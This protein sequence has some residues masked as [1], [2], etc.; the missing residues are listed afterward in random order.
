[1]TDALHGPVAVLGMACLLP[2]ARDLDEYWALL[3]EGR[4]ATGEYPEG[5]LNRALY[6][7]PRR[8]QLGK[9]YSTTGGLVDSA[10][11]E[12]GGDEFDVCHRTFARVVDQALNQA[13]LASQ[14]LSCRRV[15]IYV[16]H[17]GG[18]PELGDLV[19]A[20]MAEN[21]AQVL[22]QTSAFRRLGEQQQQALLARFVERLREGK[23]R[24]QPGGGPCWEARW[25][26]EL[27]A[28][29]HGLSGPNLVVD[30]ACAS[31]LVALALAALAL[32]RGEID[33]A[34]V[35]G[36]SI[37]KT[38]SLLLFSQAQSCSSKRSRPF[39]DLA[40]GLIGSEG[41]VAMVL[42]RAQQDWTGPAL[43]LISGIGLSSDGRGRHLWAPLREG[44]LS[45]LKRAYAGHQPATVQYIEAHATSTQVG[46]ATE[47]ESLREFFA[48]HLG[49]QKIPI[50]SVKSNIGHT[51]ETAGLASLLKVILSMRQAEIPPT[52]NLETPNR[53]IDWDSLPFEVVRQPRAWPKPEA[54][55]RRAGVSAFGIGGLNVH[56]VV[57]EPDDSASFNSS[58]LQAEPVAIIGRGLVAAGA[59]NLKQFR[60]RLETGISALGEAPGS[61]W[62]DQIGLSAT[63]EDWTTPTKRGGYVVEHRYDYLKHRVPP[64]QLERANPLQFMLLD[65]ADQAFQEAGLTSR[66]HTAAVVGTVFGGEFS[67]RLLLGLR[68][69]EVQA[70]LKG[71]LE[72]EQG[73]LLT[74]F[75]KAYFERF[76]ALL[77]ETGGFTS[78]TLASRL[79]KAFDLEGGALALEAGSCS[80][81]L[82]LRV[83]TALLQGG[84]CS[85]VLCAAGQTSLDLVGFEHLAR[86]GCFAD[87]EFFPGE[88]ASVVLLKRLADARRD[89][90]PIF[91]VLLGDGCAYG[92]RSVEQASRL[93]R[94]QAGL[95]EA[96]SS[97][98]DL[99]PLL[100][101]LGAAAGL[102]RVIAATLQPSD[103]PVE[104]QSAGRSGLA[105]SLLLGPPASSRAEP[106]LLRWSATT[107][108]ELGRGPAQDRF[109][110]DHPYRLA[111][112]ACTTFEQSQL[113]QLALDQMGQPSA[114]ALLEDKG[115]FWGEVGRR[116]PRL[117]YVF[118]GQGSQ[119]PGMM[120]DLTACSKS[121]RAVLE[122]AEAVLAGMGLPGFTQFA[123]GDGE[124]LNQDPVITQLAILIAD[125]MMFAALTEYGLEP[126]VVCGHSFG[127][128]AAL[129][130]AR[131]LTLEQAL[132]LTRVRAQ[133]LLQASP[134]G[135]LLSVQASP[136]K[137]LPLLNG[138]Q[139]YLTHRNAPQQCVIG[140]GNAELDQLAGLLHSQGLASLRLKVP[141]A[142][143]TP[144][145]APAQ[146][147]LRQQLEAIQLLP[148]SRLFYSGVN[149]A[150]VVDPVLIRR[151]LV[152]QLVQPVDHPAL[153][154]RLLADGVGALIEVG[155]G[156]VLTRLHRQ[157]VDPA[158]VLCLACDH[159]KR[160]PEEQRLRLRAALESRGLLAPLATPEKPAGLIQ[161][162]SLIEFDATAARRGRNR[163]QSEQSSA[164]AP[165][166]ASPA[167]DRLAEILLDFVVDLTGYPREAISLDWDLEAD[168]G[169]DSIKRTQ[170]IG[171][172]GEALGLSPP[173]GISLDRVT[174]LRELLQ[175][176]RAA[177]KGE[178]PE[179]ETRAAS[180][181]PTAYQE[182]RARGLRE[183]EDIRRKLRDLALQP[184]SEWPLAA[185]LPQSF[186]SGQL[187]ELQGVAD[188]A[189]VHLGALLAMT[190]PSLR[191]PSSQLCLRYR[192]GMVPLAVGPC[193]EPDWKGG[194]LILGHD[195]QALV[196]E[197]ELKQRGLP[198]QRL[199]PR[200]P[201]E[202]LLAQLEPHP[203]L[204][205]CASGP[206]Q[207]QSCLI[208]PY[209]VCQRWL[210]RL[211]Q[212]E[213]ME[214]ASLVALTRLGGDFG[215]TG[216]SQD[217][218][219]AP[220][221][222]LCKAI[223]VESWVAGYRWL[224]VKVIDS[225]LELDA[226]HCV[227]A[228]LLE[229]A[230]PGYDCEIGL[231]GGQR[232]VLRCF[233]QAAPAPA[234]DPAWQPTGNWI[235]SGGARGITAFVG[236][237]LA[238]RYGL[239][240]HLLGR[241]PRREFP[242]HWRQL[243]AEGSR[244][245]KLEVL[246]QARLGGEPN[247]AGV[248]ERTNKQL[249]IE[250][251]L[252]HF[253]SQG[254]EVHYYSC[255]LGQREQLR[256][257]L[258]KIREFGPIRGILH[259][260]GA[261]RDAKFEHKE[262]GRVEQCFAAK[263][264]GTFNL[265]ELTEQ[266]PLTHVLAFGSISGRF[267]ANGHTDY[268][269]AN[270]AMAKI[271]DRYRCSRPEVASTTIHWHAWGDVG[272]AVKAEAQYGLELVDI[273]FMP[274]AEGLQHLLA[275][276]LAGA[277]EPEVLITTRDYCARFSLA[278]SGPTEGRPL[279]GQEGCDELWLDPEKEV[280]LKEHRLDGQPMLPLVIGLE[281]LCESALP[282]RPGPFRVRQVEALNGL[283]FASSQPLKVCLQAGADGLMRLFG[284]MR[285]RDGTLLDPARPILQ[286]QIS[287]DTRSWPCQPG[288]AA[289]EWRTAE[290][291]PE[292][293]RFYHG[294]AFQVLRQVAVGSAQA[295]ARITA[296]APA[297]LAPGRPGCWKIPAAVL[298]AC[299]V[300]V[301]WLAWSEQAGYNAPAGLDEL[302][303]YRLPAPCE[304]CFLQIQSL[305]GD[306]YDFQLFGRE[307]EL[308][309]VVFGYR[310]HRL[311]PQ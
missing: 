143:H 88:G 176:L 242:P 134:D 159:P 7:D 169:I 116:R 125:S 82:A 83:G 297:E 294:P 266:D 151:N 120:R 87:P 192:L 34:I 243:W 62:P 105:C 140:G 295:W 166:A 147:A 250:A 96:P 285:A 97:S 72:P 190:G 158:E 186:P 6:Y 265:L 119:Y 170:L 178:A 240:L 261:G 63:G 94:T 156:Q 155:P 139:L 69:C 95:E 214:Q 55:P 216:S 247:P 146:A 194:A 207:R 241:Q 77:D 202:Q 98:P 199:D 2:G 25:A 296:P 258:E 189:G 66:E 277:P 60:E 226:R 54:G 102:T 161:T 124:R 61:R 132:R 45:A 179:A 107:T 259:G 300:A 181:Q 234:P 217:L 35:G 85:S 137:V 213:Q 114:R 206:Y 304:E 93:A 48:P 11:L 249:E 267:G 255:D 57:Q 215:L 279:L 154:Q 123:W 18:G 41:Y 228:A 31:S 27:V 16:G 15:G 305:G 227:E 283:K 138:H 252:E 75:E 270:D 24:R 223:L 276:L 290:Y 28:H 126:D 32:Q 117:A 113:R 1:M 20:T 141:G 310:I 19:L 280:F 289:A 33:L 51:L 39:D 42:S 81:L 208:N 14:Q 219:G 286:A 58:P 68:Y 84:V 175:L 104:I 309:L 263:L 59:H 302:L 118:A 40:D 193:Q 237:E 38:D 110:P 99:I 53:S 271:I 233:E 230:N 225:P 273:Q 254:V 196:L 183:R 70:I 220:L 103:R 152:D 238:R 191:G 74:E 50:G 129:V 135:G 12:G 153:I 257:T 29:R 264:D 89:G 246:E 80:S 144:L 184:R 76:P 281:L 64:K 195:E 293:G 188:G 201:L 224:P 251:S 149:Q 67:N 121:S 299:L 272:M 90:N 232:H 162:G 130:A 211:K 165:S 30:A 23:P 10:E 108:S 269:L 308:L 244:Q 5:R 13:G 65:A 21:I 44:Q 86:Q 136:E 56:L 92:E 200:L 133:A 284:E 292:S 78:S 306:R 172:V 3:R 111:V 9:T 239:R 185:Q 205:L 112:V 229:L 157:I 204:F 231:P 260:A 235:C 173:Q 79:T 164:P 218:A 163:A 209:W 115:V 274:A 37:A 171:Q 52:I 298:D 128:I 174:S 131:S 288:E 236:L 26:A 101:D 278:E 160:H 287:A 71:L 187:A 182:G 91:G 47:L 222:G 203:H 109:S 8:G 46:D 311:R 303:S 167:R 256:Q 268:S 210:G 197:S 291:N 253:A 221:T 245:L 148:P 275:E 36:A 106:R 198:V 145:V 301:G 177:E 4:D 212:S 282:P 122:E 150:C 49:S 307:G 180:Q 262:A 168:L 142:L 17:S 22:R 73:V 43:A 248:W 127:E 100:G